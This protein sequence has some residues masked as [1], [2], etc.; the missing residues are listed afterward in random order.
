MS[1]E[2]HQKKIVNH[3]W[4]PV[5]SNEIIMIINR[6]NFFNHMWKQ[7]MSNKQINEKLLEDCT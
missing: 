2:I 7:V 5:T 3:I 1:N 6:Q 4:K